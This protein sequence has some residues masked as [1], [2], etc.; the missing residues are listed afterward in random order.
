MGTG[1]RGGR[2]P[3][4]GLSRLRTVFWCA[5]FTSKASTKASTKAKARKFL[6]SICIRTAIQEVTEFLSRGLRSCRFIASTTAL[7]GQ[8]TW[9]IDANPVAPDLPSFVRPSEQQLD[10][11]EGSQECR[12]MFWFDVRTVKTIDVG[13]DSLRAG[14]EN[15]IR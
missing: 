9:L 15:S 2:R 5:F 14:L 10:F 8:S 1:E 6:E 4:C 7:A 13:P 11:F 12:D 3:G